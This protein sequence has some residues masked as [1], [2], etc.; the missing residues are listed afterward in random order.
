MIMH[1]YILKAGPKLGVGN[2]CTKIYLKGR[3]QRSL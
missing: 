1:P 2:V 3:E